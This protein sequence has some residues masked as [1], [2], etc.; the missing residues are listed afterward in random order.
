MS[1]PLP[2]KTINAELAKRGLKTTLAKGDGYFYVVGVEAADWLDRTVRV[3]TLHALTLDQW[4]EELQKL[5]KKNRQ[6]LAQA[7]SPKPEAKP[8]SRLVQRMD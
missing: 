4:I 6:L 1:V 3:Q 7:T 8:R 2:L 5:A